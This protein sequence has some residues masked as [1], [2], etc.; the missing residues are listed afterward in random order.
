MTDIFIRTA[1][2][3][4]AI[5]G[6]AHVV[7]LALWSTLPYPDFFGLQEGEERGI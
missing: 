5:V 3:H 1:L 7:G 4:M 2:V 6:E